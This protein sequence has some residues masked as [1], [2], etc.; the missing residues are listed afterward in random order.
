VKPIFP[1]RVPRVVSSWLALSWLAGLVGVR[2]P[3]ADPAGLS[4]PDTVSLFDGRTLEGW[5][6]NE[7][8]GSF[9]VEEGAIV[10]AGPRSHLFY[11]GPVRNA[12][13]EDFEFEAEVRAG[14][15]ANSGIYFHTAYQEKDWPTKGFEVQ[16]NNTATGEGGYREHKK[17]GSL[18]GLR[19]VHKQLVPDDPWF[20][21]RIEVRGRSVR[22]FV[23]QVQT[24]N[25]VEPDN[26]PNAG[27]EG[28]K[29][30]RGTFAL[31]CHDPGSR[32]AY[33]RLRV[34][35][36]K[37]PFPALPTPGVSAVSPALAALHAGNY[38]VIDLHTHLK[39]GL[40]V[41]DVVN[42]QFDTG[43]NAGLA[44]NAG[45][46]FPVT[47][48]V[49]LAAALARNRHPLVFT[50]IQAE[51]RE[52]PTLFS[53]E[54]LGQ[55]D[56]L[57]TDAMT[58]VDDRGRRMRLWIP[59]E[60][61]VGEPQA[62][63]DLLVRRTVEILEREPIDIWVNPTFLPASIAADYDRLWTE[64]RMRRVIEAAVRHGVAIEINDRFKLPGVAFVK[65]AR[66]AGAK[67]TFGTN[68]GGK[69]DLGRF[70]Y[71]ARVIGECGLKWSDFWVPGAGPR[72]RTA[73]R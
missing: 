63:M 8:G 10:C 28:R 18:Y 50:G 42:R 14:P 66:E 73:P 26:P 52:W 70:E 27:Y 31:Q 29:L 17:T 11:T 6:A 62:F 34:R 56:Y 41:E 69:D 32:V 59:E 33:R 55:A 5:R 65:L 35:P 45:L 16:V 60:V 53:R 13:F 44:L 64:A 54:A 23:N 67:F 72:I 1:G 37:G 9:R 4:G 49:T 39:G 19:N 68:N 58:I 43:I 30:G 38:P 20:T 46:G 61:V 7:G 57:F 24:V 47:N 21:L 22:V 3:A 51:G 12:E 48:D 40:T 25:Y 2:L 36:L 71:C 15:G